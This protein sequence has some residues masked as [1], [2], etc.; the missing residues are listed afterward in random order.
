MDSGAGHTSG[1]SSDTHNE[2]RL[3]VRPLSG[4][5]G[6]SA[7]LITNTREVLKMYTLADAKSQLI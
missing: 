3:A 1:V 7:A 2:F 5:Q 4:V 6:E